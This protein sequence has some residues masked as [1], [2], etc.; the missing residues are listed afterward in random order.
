MTGTYEASLSMALCAMFLSTS[1]TCYAQQTGTTEIKFRPSV[2]I[3]SCRVNLG[4]VADLAALPA[5]LREIAS[6]LEVFRF[7]ASSINTRL[8]SSRVIVASRRA[9]PGLGEW[10]SATQ[11]ET[12]AI[13]RSGTPCTPTTPTSPSPIVRVAEHCAF[14]TRDIEINDAVK[15]DDVRAGPCYEADSEPADL[16]YARER[17]VLVARF[18]LA[19]GQQ[20]SSRAIPFLATFRRGD[21]AQITTSIGN[22]QASRSAVAVQDGRQGRAMLWRFRAGETIEAMLSKGGA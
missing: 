15:A 20:I 5:L 14:L 9:I 21:S 18:P 22:A 13:K 19:A 2:T 17:G 12:I 6:S 16:R 7:G 3:D 1:S 4:D 8:D 11:P 10:F